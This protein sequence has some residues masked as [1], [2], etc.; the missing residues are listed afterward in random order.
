MGFRGPR[1][2]PVLHFSASKGSERDFFVSCGNYLYESVIL[3]WLRAW[4]DHIEDGI[5][6]SSG[7]MER[8]ITSFVVPPPH[9]TAS[10][11][12]EQSPIFAFFANMDFLLPLCAKSIVLR[13][14]MEVSS[15]YPPW[16]KAVVDEGHLRV[17]EP[18]VE[19]LARGLMGQALSG[20][21]QS[22]EPLDSSL[23]RA[24]ESSAVVHDFIAAL[25]A[26]LHP[27]H[28]QSLIGKFFRTLRDCETEHLGDLSS[29]DFQWTD[30]NL[31]RVR[32]SRQLRLQAIERLAVLP[33]FLAM[34]YPRKFNSNRCSSFS[35]RTKKSDWLHQHAD[36]DCGEECIWKPNAH[37]G[38]EKLPRAGW[39][40]DLLTKESLSI[41]SLSSES[42]VAE[43]MAH[44]EVTRQ[45]SSLS[46]SQ[47]RI[48]PSLKK[49]PGAS[50]K[51]SDLLMFQALSIQAITCV[52][53]LIIRRHAMDRRF[54][55]ESGR[56]RV[57]GMLAGPILEKSIASVRWLARMEANHRVRSTWLLC[58]TYVLQEAPEYYIAL[59][60]RSYCD[61]KVSSLLSRSPGF[62]VCLCFP[63]T[64]ASLCVLL[65]CRN[66]K[67]TGS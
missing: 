5:G 7:S 60:V 52:Y 64:V 25:A 42:V 23:L 22:D 13:F 67:F 39:L 33:S 29:I 10:T 66:L 36:A 4:L 20:L 65:L 49:R 17:L 63:Q 44:I 1:D 2:C 57:A 50:L 37:A 12:L 14:N 27:E 21:Q 34:N 30:E 8:K 48:A 56:G 28:M 18:F 9:A 19:M 3:L 58:V 62:S 54:Q 47:H 24:L 41:C 61:P 46:P 43:A 11:K 55:G 26:V 35:R 6:A 32:S 53:E 59:T 40:S 38:T 51:R 16:T 15:N 45:E 31:H